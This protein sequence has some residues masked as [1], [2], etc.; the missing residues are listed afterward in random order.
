MLSIFIG[1]FDILVFSPIENIYL[2]EDV[3]PLRVK[4]LLNLVLL[5]SQG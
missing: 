3:L 2:R 4:N 1:L 5:L